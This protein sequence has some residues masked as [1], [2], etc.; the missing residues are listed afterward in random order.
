MLMPWAQFFS[1]NLIQIKMILCSLNP[2]P[3]F[4]IFPPFILERY[5]E[6]I[7]QPSVIG[8][9]MILDIA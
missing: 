1:N 3:P 9:S 4:T 8:Y 7:L 5:R 6:R 2:V